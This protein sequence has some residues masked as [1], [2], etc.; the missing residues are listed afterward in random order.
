MEVKWLQNT[1]SRE[2]SILCY[3]QRQE[4]VCCTP[5][6]NLVS[7]YHT[8]VKKIF[9]SLQKTFL[10]IITSFVCHHFSLPCRETCFH[11]VIWKIL[12][13]PFL[14]YAICWQISCWSHSLFLAL[15]SLLFFF[16]KFFCWALISY[17]L[18]CWL[19]LPS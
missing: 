7:I 10:L 16:F 11:P 3:F 2:A 19:N 5:N 15:T 17:I 14:P 1:G 8:V 6:Q 12:S 13:V 9:L 4:A 18:L